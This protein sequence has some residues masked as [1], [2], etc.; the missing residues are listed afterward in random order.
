[1]E[2]FRR[3]ARHGQ[4]P[5]L[6]A[7]ANLERSEHLMQAP[8]TDELAKV[9]TEQPSRAQRAGKL[10]NHFLPTTLFDTRPWPSA[11]PEW[12]SSMMG[13]GLYRE[14]CRTCPMSQENWA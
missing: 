7:L 11:I 8:T 9:L 13:L 3:A 10:R 2:S 12:Y 5:M 1:M 4:P 6:A 14:Y